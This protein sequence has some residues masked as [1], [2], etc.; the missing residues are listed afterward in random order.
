M[1][2]VIETTHVNVLG[3]AHVLGAAVN[4]ARPPRVV[5][6]GSAEEYGPDAPLP[7]REDGPA[8][9]V[10]AYGASKL[11]VTEIA[12]AAARAVPVVVVRPSVVYG[13][14]QPDRMLIA[15]AMRA[16]LTDSVC[17]VNGG[18]Q[19]RDHVHVDDVARALL[20]AADRADGAARGRVV[21]AASGDVRSVFDTA[22]RVVVI[23]GRGRIERGPASSRQ[24]DVM[25]M[26]MDVSLAAQLLDWR[27]SVT[28]DEGIRRTLAVLQ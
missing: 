20:C 9:P 2:H 18:T 16:A 10:S 5:L 12:R 15:C 13:P 3:T 8:R 4:M 25:E 26:S 24:G 21:N 7:Y 23:A 27:A 17:V 6:V 22:Q 11:A 1:A 14:G 19:T 28:L